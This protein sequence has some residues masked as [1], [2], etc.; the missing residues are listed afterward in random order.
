[1]CHPGRCA[2]PEPET[3]AQNL[4]TSVLSDGPLSAET[5]QILNRSG[6]AE[7]FEKYPKQVFAALHKGLPT[8][9]EKDK[10]F[11]LTELSFLY[12]SRGGP[13]SYFP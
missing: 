6:L 7:K 9:T 8:A 1:M 11:A 4:A 13:K 12:A 3:G 5:I 2:P 10:L